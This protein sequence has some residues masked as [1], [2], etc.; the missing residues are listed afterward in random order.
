MP[1]VLKHLFLKLYTLKYNFPKTLLTFLIHAHQN[2]HGVCAY[3]NKTN[4]IQ[5]D[6]Y[7]ATRNDNKIC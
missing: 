4:K 1:A 5:E 6:K 7:L 2:T 3:K